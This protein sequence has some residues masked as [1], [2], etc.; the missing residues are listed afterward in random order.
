MRIILSA[1]HFFQCYNVTRCHQ[2]LSF[3]L[4]V[5]S[6]WH[7]Q[8]PYYITEQLNVQ[9]FSGKGVKVGE[10]DVTATI[11]V[12]RWRVRELHL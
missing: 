5:V 10:R 4:F 2:L 1:I 9:S 11:H 7:W 3:V 12:P 6:P 8:A